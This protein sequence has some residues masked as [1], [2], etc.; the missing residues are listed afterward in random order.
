MPTAKCPGEITGVSVSEHKGYFCYR[1][2]ALFEVARCQ[3][4]A[5][6]VEDVLEGRVFSCEFKL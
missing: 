4:L 1:K 5:N 6:V 3:A 2:I